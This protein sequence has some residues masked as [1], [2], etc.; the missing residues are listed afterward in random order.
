VENQSV[1]NDVTK[2]KGV[3]KRKIDITD[4]QVEELLMDDQIKERQSP[5]KKKLR[6]AEVEK[7]HKIVGLQPYVDETTSN[8]PKVSRFFVKKPTNAESGDGTRGRR[9]S[10][11]DSVHMV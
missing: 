11:G 3:E 6:T 10:T 7:L 4:E 9:L 1:R 8:K 2:S 5:P